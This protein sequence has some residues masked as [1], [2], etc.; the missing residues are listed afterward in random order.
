[1]KDLIEKIKKAR[2]I[3]ICGN[4]GSASTAEH[5]TTD[6]IK[7]GY[8]AICLNSNAS[9]ITMI[10]NDFNYDKIFS[11]QLR[12]LASK[13]DLLI[14]ISCSGVS[15][16]ITHAIYEARDKRIPLYEF[17]EFTDN[18]IR[19]STP[20]DYAELE[21]KHLKFAHEVALAL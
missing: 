7:K 3:F 20:E 15:G 9:V 1:M 16:N 11:E 13:E 4:G 5:F 8:R 21:D 18:Q 12:V 14:T 10:A 6:L 2:F 19:H 17:E